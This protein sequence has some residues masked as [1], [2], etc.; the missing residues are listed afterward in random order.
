[1]SL[2]RYSPIVHNILANDW[3]RVSGALFDGEKVARNEQF[4]PRVDIRSEA[5]QYVIDVELPGVDPVTVELTVEQGIL[6]LKGER[7]TPTPADG[8][9]VTRAERLS[10]S[11]FRRFNLPE[12]ANI[13]AV[14]ATEKWGVLTIAVPRKQKDAPKK[15]V[16]G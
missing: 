16:I 10:G 14:A 2:V 5:S 1:M 15:I 9:S 3:Q 8:V 13:E 6:Q 11:F 4:T 12:D 7:V